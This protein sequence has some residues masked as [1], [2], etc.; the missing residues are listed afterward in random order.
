MPAMMVR[1]VSKGY[2]GTYGVV[3][4]CSVVV[5]AAEVSFCFMTGEPV[6]RKMKNSSFRL[7]VQIGSLLKIDDQD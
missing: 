3:L 4:Y 1:L 7:E 2:G 6:C 5:C